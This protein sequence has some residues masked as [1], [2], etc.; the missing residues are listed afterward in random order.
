MISLITTPPK[1]AALKPSTTK[2]AS[3]STEQLEA[4]TAALRTRDLSTVLEI[5]PEKAKTL[6]TN[7]KRIRGDMLQHYHHFVQRGLQTILRIS[8]SA[9]L[10]SAV[11]V[12]SI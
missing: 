8:D 1:A 11:A 7:A 4:E 2:I 5:Q 6:P 12:D 3:T 10:S 9:P